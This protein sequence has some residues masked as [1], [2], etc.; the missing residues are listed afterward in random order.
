M[1][2]FLYNKLHECYLEDAPPWAPGV[3]NIFVPFVPFAFSVVKFS[4]FA[5]IRVDSRLKIQK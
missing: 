1:N 5:T 3:R 4:S 2:S